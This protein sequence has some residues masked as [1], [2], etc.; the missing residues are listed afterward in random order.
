MRWLFL[1]NLLAVV[2]LSGAVAIVLE[3]TPLPT[4]RSALPT[5]GQDTDD[6]PLEKASLEVVELP[7][8]VAAVQNEGVTVPLPLPAPRL[9]K[10]VEQLEAETLVVLRRLRIATEGDFAPFNFQDDKGQPV[11]F[12]IDI[13]TELCTRLNRECIIETR[14]WNALQ[15][16][17]TNRDVDMLV[18][19]IQIPS[20]APS[21][22]LFSDPY[23]G[24]HGR[25]V[26]PA[27][28]AFAADEIFP[29]PGTQIAVQQS[30]A[31]AAYLE[32][33]YPNIERV[34]TRTFTEALAMV[35]AGKVES[36]FGD[37]ATALRW[38]K[39]K[40]CCVV[41]GAPVSDL[42]FFGQGIGIAVRADERAL[43]AEINQALEQM[44][45][46]GTHARL[47]QHYFADSIY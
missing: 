21:G 3:G 24:S 2:L 36:A 32:S 15:S 11:G 17:L 42:T 18:S 46:D 27:D 16:A 1:I 8:E 26:G 10:S 29:L 47:S 31:H 4:S 9:A 7:Q 23:Y 34:S 5:A 13:A 39:A 25:F 33:A 28:A 30:T 22:I 43:L 44:V 45:A 41:M 19:S 14:A 12:D 6:Q 35:E 20:K 40:T 37:N 38:L